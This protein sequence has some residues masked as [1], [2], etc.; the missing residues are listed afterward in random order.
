MSLILVI[1]LQ[2]EIATFYHS[3]LRNM[4]KRTSEDLNNAIGIPDSNNLDG[5]ADQE[6]LH[7]VSEL[8]ST[9]D[10]VSIDISSMT[11]AAL[12]AELNSEFI[13][14]DRRSGKATLAVLLS[15]TI[16][17]RSNIPRLNEDVQG[18]IVSFRSFLVLIRFM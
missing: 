13:K 12:K 6:E 8:D 3:S 14:F 2:K 10:G 11:V 18:Y 5:G 17:A 16:E 15:E 9:T 1:V 7:E 4:S